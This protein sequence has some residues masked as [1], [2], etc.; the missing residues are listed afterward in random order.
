MID[1]LT[2]SDYDDNPDPNSISVTS[3]LSPPWMRELRLRH[4]DEITVDVMDRMWIMIGEIGHDI[5]GRTSSKYIKEHRVTIPMRVGDR[6]VNVHGK[7]DLYDLSQRRLHDNKFTSK[8][9]LIYQPTGKPEWH[10]QMNIYAYIMRQLGMKVESLSLTLILRDWTKLDAYDHKMPNIPIVPLEVPV[11][12]D[13]VILAFLNQR[14]Q[15]HFDDVK[16]VCSFEDRWGKKDIWAVKDKPDAKRAVNGGLCETL[17]DANAL[18]T[19]YP[20]G[21]VEFRKGKDTRCLEY[22]EVSNFCPYYLNNYG[23]KND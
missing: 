4:K 22:C 8:G 13:D 6:T 3:L 20:K 14:L 10:W 18:L 17:Q 11:Y 21:H 12:S 7:Y 2:H 1:A 19:K 5:A 9:T 16:N 15:A 23:G